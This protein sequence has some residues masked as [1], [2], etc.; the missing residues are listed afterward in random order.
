MKNQGVSSW[1]L[2]VPVAHPG[3]EQ[4]GPHL[5][6]NGLKELSLVLPDLGMVD[7]LEQLGVFVDEPCLAEDIGRSIFDLQEK[8]APAAVQ[9]VCDAVSGMQARNGGHGS[10]CTDVS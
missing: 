9:G 7:L 6:M 2:N 4:E 1:T 3:P 10:V 8:K 5:L